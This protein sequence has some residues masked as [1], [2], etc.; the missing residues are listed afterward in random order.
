MTRCPLCGEPHYNTIS[1]GE[2]YRCGTIV[3]GSE[4]VQHRYCQRLCSPDTMNRKARRPSMIVETLGGPRVATDS[5]W[6]R[7]RDAIMLMQVGQTIYLEECDRNSA[8]KA[9]Y[10]VAGCRQISLLA[11]EST[12][13]RPTS[14]WA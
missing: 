14:S 8:H 7:V 12:A 4:T 9:A 1:L 11:D 6:K 10:H 2:Q 3:N 5:R 13:G